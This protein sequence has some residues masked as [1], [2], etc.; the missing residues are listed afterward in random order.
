[1]EL[2]VAVKCPGQRFDLSHCCGQ[3]AGFGQRH[4]AVQPDDR[5]WLQ[6]QKAVVKQGDLAPV[7]AA[8]RCRLH[9]QGGN[10]GLD[11][12]PAWRAARHCAVQQI[13]P[14]ADHRG[15]PKAAILRLQRYQRALH[16]AGRAAGMGQQHQ[17]QKAFGFRFARTQ[18]DQ[19]ARQKDRLPVPQ[20]GCMPPARL[21]G[22][23]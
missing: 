7:G 22:R 3:R 5:R 16:N 15:I 10:R 12:K 17:G 2:R 20:E 21:R 1:M 4:R 23:A 6:P 11:L 14:L 18:E 9:M 8:A 13:Q 19:P